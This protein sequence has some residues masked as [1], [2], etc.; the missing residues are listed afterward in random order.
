MSGRLT[1]LAWGVALLL[2]VSCGEEERR[3]WVSILPEREKPEEETEPAGPGALSLGADSAAVLLGPDTLFTLGRLPPEGP[4]D[5][6]FTPTA[7]DT[8][9]FDPDSVLVAFTTTG[10]QSAVGVW[11][12]IQQVGV[13]ASVYPE[14]VAGRLQ[15][16]PEG[17]FLA[18]EGRGPGSSSRV[19]AYDAR[20]AGPVRQPVLTWLAR[21]GRSS[22]YE[23]WIDARRLRVLVSP[24][25][26]PT[27]GLAHSWDL[28]GSHFVLESHIEPLTER[29]PPE[30]QLERGGVVSVDLTGDL[31]PETVALYRSGDGAPGAILL[32]E[33]EGGT[34]QTGVTSPLV[35]GEYLGV[36]SWE[37]VQ[38][39]ARLYAVVDV[40][41]RT[42]LVLSLPSPS[43]LDVIGL[44]QAG[45][46]GR[47]EPMPLVE[48]DGTEGPALFF[49]GATEDEIV[50]FGLTDLD[51]DGRAEIVSATGEPRFEGVTSRIEWSVVAFRWRN[52]RLGPDPELAQAALEAIERVTGTSNP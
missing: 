31:V 24:G 28:D 6:A 39:G 17:R 49:D 30:A 15:W 10:D 13:L 25:T 41:D 7:F 43:P 42:V 26:D 34:F 5:V 16:G 33:R 23:G 47:L 32:R 18:Y 9:A 4:G 45:T 12:R 8:V 46:D 50:Q 20:I 1:A 11:S 52:G 51:G 3:A 37:N 35:P 36:E 38:V 19:G 29:A 48:E 14:A 22:R 44:F 40:G 27:G 2:A 21:R